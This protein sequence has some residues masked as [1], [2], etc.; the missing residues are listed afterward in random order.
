MRAWNPGGG[1]PNY[2]VFFLMKFFSERPSTSFL[3]LDEEQGQNV[4]Y[5]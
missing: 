5:Q 2:E 4:G 3:N 1:I